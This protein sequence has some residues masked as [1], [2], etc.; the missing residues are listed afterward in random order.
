M[1]T[2]KVA[3]FCSSPRRDRGGTGQLLQ[4]L[5]SGLREGGATVDLVQLAD[6]TVGACRGCLACWFATPG[7]CSQHDDMADLLALFAAAD[8]VVLATPLYVDGM[9]GTMKMF[10]DRCLPLLEPFFVIRNGHCRHEL[11]QGV[12][13]GQL[14]LVSVSGFTELDNFDPLLEHVQAFCRN[15]SR[16]FAGALL[17][18]CAASL[19]EFARHGLPVSDVLAAA[20]EAGRWLAKEGRIPA[21]LSARVSRELV[22]RS[23]YVAAVNS[24]FRRRLGEKKQ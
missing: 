16:E 23:V 1:S 2:K 12:K 6:K 15:V 4:P 24:H 10:L 9:T 14:A 8:L 17:R 18:P 7:R 5:I 3:V 19:P 21:E 13:A 20:R 11:R 22:P